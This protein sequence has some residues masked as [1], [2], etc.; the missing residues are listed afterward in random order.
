MNLSTLHKVLDYI[1]E[2]EFKL[3]SWGD[4]GGSFTEEELFSIFEKLLPEEDP[5][6]ILDE[7]IDHAIITSIPSYGQ[8]SLYRSR[9]AH[10]VHLYRNLR[11]WMHGQ[12][13]EASKSLVS[14][15]RFLR[16]PRYYPTRNISFKD[17]LDEC[18]KEKISDPIIR[19]SL[20]NQIGDFQLSGFQI[21]STIRTINA[22]ERHKTRVRFPSAT[23]TC[24]GT[25]SGKTMAFYL[26][27]LSCLAKDISID[28]SER[29]RIL[30]IYPRQEL[31]KDQFNETWN[32]CRKL[33]DITTKTAGRKI[34]I[35]ALF[36]NTP[37]EAQYALKGN[38]QYFYSGLIQCPTK[39]CDGQ[40]RWNKADIQK[41]VERLV[42]HLCGNQILD[43]EIVLTRKSMQNN[44]P[45]ILFTTTEMLNQN[46]GN[47]VR[48]KLFGIETAKPIPLVLLDE[49]HTYSGNQGAQTA[50]LLR[51]WMKLSNSAPHFVGLSATLSDAQNFFSKLT[52]TRSTSVMLVEPLAEEM[53]EEGAEYLLALRGDPVSQTALLS[54][55]IQ[56][57][58]LTRRIL[59]HNKI[60]PSKG[61]W[62]SKTFLFTDDL[63]VN[64]RLYS[65]L[66]DAEGF[67]QRKGLLVEHEKGPLAKLRNPE[68]NESS[69]TDDMNSYGQDWSALKYNGFSLDDGDRANV[70][71]T[72]SQDSGVEKESDMVVATAS[73]EVGFNDPD[74]GA[75]IQHK[76]PR[77][78]ASY[79]QRKGRA[80]RPRTMRPWTVIVLSEF[81]KDRETFQHYESL[82]DPEVK[83]LGLPVD[84]THIHRMQGAM[85]TLDWLS[86]KINT[87]LWLL[88][89]QPKDNR[90]DSVKPHL[91]ELL[92][93]V[94]EL[95]LTDSRSQNELSDYLQ[96]ALMLNESQITAILWQSPR[97]ILL[98]FLP[99][100]RK[101]ITTQW[102]KWD[103]WNNIFITWSEVNQR[104]GSPVP[105]FIPA[106]LFSDLNLPSIDIALN[107]NQTEPVW[108]GMRFFQAVKDFAPGRISKR[109]STYSGQSSDWLIPSGF[110]PSVGLHNSCQLFEIEQAF[111][112][113][114]NEIGE[115]DVPGENQRITV[116]RPHQIYPQ[117]L[118]NS[119]E[120][121]ETSNAFL[122]WKSI[123]IAPEGAEHHTP[124]SG[125]IWV[126]Y[127][128][129]ISF[130]TH[131]TMTPL[132]IVRYNTG[133]ECE[134]K[135]KRD[136]QKARVNFDWVK[137]T[138]P[139]GVGA[140]LTAD[141][142]G[143]RFSIDIEMLC[144]WLKDKE[145]VSSLRSGFLQDL[146]R[147]SNLCDRNP[148]MSDW[149][150]ECFVA[151]ISLEAINKC[152]DLKTAIE[153]IV[154]QK[155][156]Y[157]LADMPSM[158]FQ[159]NISIEEGPSSDE[160]EL[161]DQKLQK[162]LREKLNNPVFV[163]AL[164]DLG[165]VLHCDLF[166]NIEFIEWSKD[167]LGNTLAAGIHQMACTIM[168]QIDERSLVVDPIFEENSDILNI[169]LSE[170]DSGGSG[171][172]TQLQDLYAE[173]P[174]RVLGVLSR[175]FEAGDYERLDID[176]QEVLKSIQENT[177]VKEMVF[178]LR[179]VETYKERI[180]ANKSLKNALIR[181]GFQYSH[182]FSA[183]LYS[184]ILKS[185][186]N[187]ESDIM[188]S[189]YLDRWKK[190]EFDL[191]MEI[192]MNIAG[193]LLVATDEV[194][195][196]KSEYFE[197]AC[198]IQSVLWPRGSTVRQAILS[199]YNPFKTGGY[200]TE[201]LIAAKLCKDEIDNISI[202][203]IDWLDQLHALLNNKGRGNLVIPRGLKEKIA[204][205]LS[206]IHVTP[207]DTNGLLFYPRMKAVK[208]LNDDTILTI[209][210]AEAII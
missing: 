208:Y 37:S 93:I 103:F 12:K 17:I 28:S 13:L 90:S 30:A 148:F 157:L 47:P 94:E 191:G 9:M 22:W 199:F 112:T 43:D 81:G 143:F 80:G 210:L 8:A 38:K 137:N 27:A 209:E 15:F 118:F 158:L 85:A 23:I 132:N 207:V 2:Q 140:Q 193:L 154:S 4:T 79:L 127:L 101:R 91:T 69:S 146:I 163:K 166:E 97:P 100:L 185:G 82:L 33:D 168:P 203:E 61:T 170:Q 120:L 98:E 109:F 117:S 177:S 197:R 99:T 181:Q 62:G 42:C 135:F 58:M 26:P 39:N 139:V 188:L 44:P 189:K 182:S 179:N 153:S 56:A 152:C 155:S 67:W 45:D 24:A 89:N 102:G 18:K 65:Q 74:V 75:V 128:K 161:K 121:S 173:D 167:V 50:F 25:G 34:R 190:I 106:Q 46:I 144:F 110:V 184:R 125:S 71:R 133:S 116:Y 172:I 119:K 151:A 129:K 180:T 111:G 169:W 77:N 134:L 164:A 29:V 183:V 31:L 150:Y 88:L 6:D 147:K 21:R 7:L 141:A 53:E 131:R 68:Y 19:E 52:G 195:T 5:D 105:E 175:N 202:T 55:T 59:D 54:T 84:N 96:S 198:K 201:R 162:L 3:L 86:T 92:N 126:E 196:D 32:A 11:Q 108:E 70:S 171:V 204:S 124:P 66:A 20:K 104:W 114:L 142:I 115:F 206:K 48:Q 107:R 176:L 192:P 73:L 200:R 36:G 178:K 1:E 76:A 138:Q 64:N 95:L 14:D 41:N 72:S 63:D 40:M 16:R 130:Y 187:Q 165:N 156:V 87:N 205:A 57:A 51:R 123:F 60:K 10:A 122:K 149:I 49:V 78:V 174:H 136:G 145:L 194:S 113:S 160:L 159:Q 83:I 35:G 186:S